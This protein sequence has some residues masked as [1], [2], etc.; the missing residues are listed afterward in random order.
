MRVD[1]ARRK[2]NSP[3][4]RFQASDSS[5]FRIRF[6][7]RRTVPPGTP[8]AERGRR[9]RG[10]PGASVK[11]APDC[12]GFADRRYRHS[13][14]PAQK[15]ARRASSHQKPGP[16]VAAATECP[17]ADTDAPGFSRGPAA[18]L[19]TLPDSRASASAGPRHKKGARRPEWDDGRLALWFCSSVVQL[20]VEETL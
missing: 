8:G 19:P 17:A 9:G 4:N 1:S 14:I 20:L 5:F 18:R 11:W 12:A 3:F 16:S 6:K 2:F 7:N 15:A 10:K 13:P